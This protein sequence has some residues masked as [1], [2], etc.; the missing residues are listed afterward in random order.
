MVPT[1]NSPLH[2]ILVTIVGMQTRAG[3]AQWIA[4]LLGFVH[5]GSYPILIAIVVFMVAS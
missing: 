5:V 1:V 2:V 4:N 3:K